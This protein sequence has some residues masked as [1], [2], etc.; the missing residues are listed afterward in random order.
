MT[1]EVE[2]FD[3]VLAT[4]TAMYMTKVKK[5]FNDYVAAKNSE[6]DDLKDELHRNKKE[7]E[8]LQNDLDNAIAENIDLQQENESRIERSCPKG[9]QDIYNVAIVDITT[10]ERLEEYNE[11]LNKEDQFD[12]ALEIVRRDSRTYKMYYSSTIEPNKYPVLYFKSELPVARTIFNYIAKE[13]ARK[14][15]ASKFKCYYNRI[16]LKKEIFDEAVEYLTFL[17]DNFRDQD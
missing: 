1:M 8:E 9:F 15:V 3:A 11:K 5:A 7:L 2:R 14:Y 10:G 6:I 17:I 4:E 16:F 13:F 12:K